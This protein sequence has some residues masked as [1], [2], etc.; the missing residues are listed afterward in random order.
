MNSIRKIFTFGHGQPNFPGYVVVYGISRGD[1][2]DKMY[3][4][5]GPKWSMEYDS[6]EDAG[7]ERYSLPLITTIGV[8]LTR[9]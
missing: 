8:P 9:M 5:Y 4:A 7:A 6:E 2:R 1:C 3:Q